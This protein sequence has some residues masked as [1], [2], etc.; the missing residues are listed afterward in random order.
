MSWD[1]PDTADSQ[2]SRAKL[3]DAVWGQLEVYD[4]TSLL[5]RDRASDG[6][7]LLLPV[8]GGKKI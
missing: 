8:T 2:K 7:P 6:F 4:S 1:S 5:D 3:S